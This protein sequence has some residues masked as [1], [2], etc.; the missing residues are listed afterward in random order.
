MLNVCY[1]CLWFTVAGS[2]SISWYPFLIGTA[3]ASASAGAGDGG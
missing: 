3:S 1:I 2:G